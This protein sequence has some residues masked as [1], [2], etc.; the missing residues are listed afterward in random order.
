MSEPLRA[1]STT[2]S[3]ADFVKELEVHQKADRFAKGLYGN[4]EGFTKGCAV[5]CSL[6]SIAR[7]KKLKFRYDDHSLYPVHLGIP[8]W[9][10][11]V[12]DSIFEGLPLERSKKWPVE[13]AQ[14]INEGADLEKVKGPFLI[15]T[16]KETLKTFDHSAYPDVKAAVDGSIALWEREDIGSAEWTKAA[17]RAGAAEAAEA[18]EPRGT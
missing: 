8:E 9:L 12:E 13:F 15:S 17:A 4:M 5:G 18:A 16:L 7:T 1:Y 3:K 11:R 10:A 14:A 6:E 2:I